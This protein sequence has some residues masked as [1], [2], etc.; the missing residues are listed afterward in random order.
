MEYIKKAEILDQNAVTRAI[1]RI[2]Y[3]IIEKNQGAEDVILA[4]IKTRGE[5][6]ALRIA[7]KI[8]DLEKIQIPVI[9][10]GRAHV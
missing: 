5:Y 8:S 9:E 10:I 7:K 6:L 1:N 4:G 3:E 2:S